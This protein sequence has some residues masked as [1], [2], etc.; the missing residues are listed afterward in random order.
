MPSPP[1]QSPT[2]LKTRM[3]PLV[4]RIKSF[5]ETL[6]LPVGKALACMPYAWRPGIRSTYRQRLRDIQWFAGASPADRRRFVFERVRRVVAFAIEH[7]PFYREYYR[8]CRFHLD[9]LN[10]FEDLQR[11]PIV[12]KSLLRGC[13][14]ERRSCNQ[15]GRYVVNTGGS[16]GEPLEFYIMP[17]AI[18]HEWAHMH[19]IWSRFGY[20]PSHL[21]AGF[22]GRNVGS[23]AVVYDALR[24]QLTVNVYRP[25]A[26]IAAELM[27]VLKKN[28]VSYLHGYPSALY[29]FACYCDN[30]EP[31]LLVAMRSSL[32]GIFLGSEFPTPVYRTQIERV[33]RTPTISWYG[34]TERAVLAWEKLGAFRYEPF[35]TYGYAEAVADGATGR[36]RLVATSYYNVASPFIRYDTGDD[37]EVTAAEENLLQEYTVRAGR[38]G[39][40]I[41]DKHH[42]RIPLTGLIF[43]RHHGL[44]DLARFVQIEQREPGRAT[45][46]VTPRSQTTTVGELAAQFDGSNV[47][48]SFDVVLTERPVLSKA[49]KVLLKV[50]RAP[51]ERGEAS[52]AGA[53]RP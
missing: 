14:L 33:F 9:C 34:H 40:F 20:R 31:E 39:D 17:N 5:L 8:D 28:P 30:N 45:V 7:V 21:K 1:G 13:E 11:I 25:H 24:H 22:G 27:R 19:T 29:D 53:P 38:E 35:Q 37:V 42:K 26:E 16:S 6:P 41:L 49:G 46:I 3:T 44:F 32:R 51:T 50:A 12:T 47:D 4:P 15:P 43:G 18:G 36:T 10:D 48:I 2:K 52:P 23:K